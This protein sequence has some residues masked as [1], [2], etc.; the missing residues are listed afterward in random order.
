MARDND[1]QENALASDPMPCN[2]LN[3]RTGVLICANLFFN[4]P[5]SLEVN[6]QQPKI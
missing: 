4:K 6:I 3:P 2:G 1:A 5:L